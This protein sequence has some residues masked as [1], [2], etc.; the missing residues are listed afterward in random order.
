MT[1]TMALPDD[2]N[3]RLSRMDA[4]RRSLAQLCMQ[5]DYYRY[6]WQ[7]V[8]RSDDDSGNWARDFGTAIHKGMEAGTLLDALAAFHAAYDEA[9]KGPNAEQVE[10][11]HDETCW[12]CGRPVADHPPINHC[13]S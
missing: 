2:A 8:P 11:V 7:R 10:T 4:S 5:K 12:V 13:G 9:G 6:M 3:V 1:Q